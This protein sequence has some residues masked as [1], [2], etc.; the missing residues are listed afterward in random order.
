MKLLHLSLLFT[1]VFPFQIFASNWT[2]YHEHAS[3]IPAPYG[4]SPQ[5]YCQQ[6][7]GSFDITLADLDVFNTDGYTDIYWFADPFQNTALPPSTNVEDGVTYYA[8]QAVDPDALYLEVL[9]EM[10]PYMPAPTGD[11][12]QYFTAGCA[13][14]LSDAAVFNTSGYD[15]IIW[16]TDCSGC[17]PIGEPIDPNTLVQNGDVYYATQGI[18]DC[19]PGCLEITFQAIPPIPAPTGDADQYFTEG[20][21]FTLC[22]AAV[23]N[24][25]GYDGIYWFADAQQC[26]EIDPSI[27]VE[28]GD[29]YYAFQGVCNCMTECQCILPLQVS[30]HTLPIGVAEKKELFRVYPNPVTGVLKL[31][32]L[33]SVDSI[34]LSVLAKF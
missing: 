24:T 13:M 14:H 6:S 32:F 12:V 22:D 5:S 9:V 27:E 17:G 18:N 3:S 21:N 7:D 2:D 33:Q 26:T 25:A 30:F 11:S 34:D 1:L 8:F 16:Y 19:C 4:D 29:V 10:I 23:F 28:D 15:Q 31:D 20:M